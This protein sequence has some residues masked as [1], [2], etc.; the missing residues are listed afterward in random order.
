MVIFGKK[1]KIIRHKKNYYDP[2]REAPNFLIEIATL[3]TGDMA[4]KVLF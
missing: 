3:E 4:Q 1:Q 2:G